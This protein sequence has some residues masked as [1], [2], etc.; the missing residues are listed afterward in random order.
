MRQLSLRHK[1]IAKTTISS[2]R[3]NA[4]PLLFTAMR[5]SH[6]LTKSRTSSVNIG[7]ATEIQTFGEV[8]EKSFS[9]FLTSNRCIHVHNFLIIYV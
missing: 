9:K 4:P 8:H 1:Y 2:C 5:R 7:V 3:N 6:T